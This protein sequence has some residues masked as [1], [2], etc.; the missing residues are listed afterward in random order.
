M[1]ANPTAY[2]Y[3]RVSS[4]RQVDEGCSLEEQ[5]RRVKGRAIEEGWELA[6]VFCEKGISGSI[7][8]G[9]RPAGAELLAVVKPG[10]VVVASKLDR[11]FRSARDALEVIEDFRARGIHLWL[12]DMGDVSGNGVS[13]LVVT[14]L[15][16]VAE[17]ERERIGE[18]IRDAKRHQRQENKHLGGIRPFGFALA[19]Q[20]LGDKRAPALVPIAAEQQAIQVMKD[21]RTAGRTLREITATIRE[22]GFKIS[23]EGVRQ[24][25]LREAALAPVE[26][27]A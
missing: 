10:D 26:D 1:P 27:A 8:L 6:W 25:L 13:Q 3:I 19:P 20:P 24:V 7:P 2:A 22:Q 14:V 12:L 5:E 11:M 9:E 16:A 18:R 15:A 21:L 23:H 17:F 4:D